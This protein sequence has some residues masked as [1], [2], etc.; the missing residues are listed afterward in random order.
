[1]EKFWAPFLVFR[2]IT[3]RRKAEE[4]LETGTESASHCD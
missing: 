3:E 4:A 1:M 2:D